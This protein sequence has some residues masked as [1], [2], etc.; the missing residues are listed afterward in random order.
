MKTQLLLALVVGVVLVAGLAL[1]KTVSPVAGTV[2]IV[3]G[4]VAS[5]GLRG[6]G[7]L[8]GPTAGDDDSL[9]SDD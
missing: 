6:G 2:L 8:A 9:L 5:L 1:G 7:W 4:F 3:V